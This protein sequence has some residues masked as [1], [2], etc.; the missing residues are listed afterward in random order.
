MSD[1]TTVL[2]DD[3]EVQTVGLAGGPSGLRELF[4]YTSLVC[5]KQC[6]HCFVSSSPTNRILDE[7]TVVDL[8]PIL[9]DAKDA[10]LQDVYFT[11]GEPF[12]SK[13]IE[14]MLDSATEVAP[15]TVY[16]NAT[17]PLERCFRRGLESINQKHISIHGRPIHLRIS[18]DHYEP[19]IH[20]IYY[21]RGKGAFEKSM[22]VA[23]L[24]FSREFTVSINTQED[25]HNRANARQI[26]QF[27]RNRFQSQ[28]VELE[29]V[30]ILPDIPTGNQ[31]NRTSWSDSPV[32]PSEF[33]I[34]GVKPENL[35]CGAG[36]TV[37][38]LHGRVQVFPCTLL[39]PHD[40]STIHS[41]Q[42][43]M[44]GSSLSDSMNREVSLD[45]PSCRAYCVKGKM[46]CAN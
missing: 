15:V 33:Q 1:Y 10:G 6:S 17:E 46:S 27:L 18:L 25:L 42:K 44:M 36:R 45:H 16:T 5:N 28:G 7:M 43:Y 19:E 32:S 21:G 35:M 38:K 34:S 23:S 2:A 9:K 39:I 30:K 8:Y 26:E 14:G 11:G 24:A 31:K 3:V 22:E 29:D 13:E 37:A 12:L 4:I 40:E 41:L 20:D